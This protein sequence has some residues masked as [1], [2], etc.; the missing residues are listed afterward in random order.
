MKTFSPKLLARHRQRGI[1][2]VTVLILLLLSLMAVMGSFRV[3]NLNEAMLGS[4]ADY[5]RAFAAAE[6]LMRDAEFDI[7]GRRPPYTSQADGALGWPCRPNPK[8]SVT[9][10]DSLVGYLGCR[11]AAAANTPWF[12]RD[13]DDFDSVSDIVTANDAVRR[14]KSGICVPDGITKLANLEVDLA[15]MRA[16]G[17]TYGQFTRQNTFDAALGVSSNPI[18]SPPDGVAR[19]WYWVELFRYNTDSP[20]VGSAIPSKTKP[21]IY[22]VTV[23]ALGLK[24]GTQVVLRS[25][26][27]P[28]PKKPS[29]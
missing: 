10:L 28:F 8:D 22:R 9:S 6:A 11:N 13:N 17:A 3:A 23:V 14:C 15:N 7:M 12:P 25:M 2:L 1:S 20:E 29:S 21:Y 27:V 5:N 16:L 4:T 26:Y 19:G 18:L 24:A